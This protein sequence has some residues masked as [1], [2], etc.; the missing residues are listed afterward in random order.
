MSKKRENHPKITK[1]SPKNPILVFKRA[2]NSFCIFRG[3][4]GNFSKNKHNYSFP[5]HRKIR[6]KISKDPPKSRFS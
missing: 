1:R 4:F 6:Q 3:S 2:K 5:F